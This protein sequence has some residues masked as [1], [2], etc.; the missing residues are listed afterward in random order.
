MFVNGK[1]TAELALHQAS[2]RNM[3]ERELREKDNLGKAAKMAA[4]MQ[5]V[6]IEGSGIGLCRFLQRTYDVAP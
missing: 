2:Y 6:Q 3:L 4:E 5:K 1:S